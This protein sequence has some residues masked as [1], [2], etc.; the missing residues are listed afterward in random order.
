MTADTTGTPGS[1]IETLRRNG[2]LLTLEEIDEGDVLI[3]FPFAGRWREET[4]CHRFVR[5]RKPID[6]IH[7]A[8]V[9]GAAASPEA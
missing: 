8:L 2:S 1:L 5:L 6:G 4:G 7:Y 3:D 9:K